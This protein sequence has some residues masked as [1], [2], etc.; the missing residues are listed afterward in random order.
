MSLERVLQ[1]LATL[2]LS[3]LD[4]K[5]YVYIS[6]KGPQ[7]AVNLSRVL[8]VSKSTIYASLKSLVNKGLVTKNSTVYFALPFE[9]ALELLI[10][11]KNKQA[12]AMN[13]IKENLISWTI[14][15]NADS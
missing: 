6:N 1:T 13:G 11:T 8:N 12:E 14:N 7:K 4:A 10:E 3:K 9:E 5:I 2:G 15:D